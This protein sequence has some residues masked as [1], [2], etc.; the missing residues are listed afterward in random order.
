[1]FPVATPTKPTVAL[2]ARLVWDGEELAFCTAPSRRDGGLDPALSAKLALRTDNSPHRR[3][4]ELTDRQGDV[5]F[6]AR[7]KLESYATHHLG[8]GGK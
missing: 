5:S 3:I 2:M 8:P 1:M 4:C 7:L 6:G